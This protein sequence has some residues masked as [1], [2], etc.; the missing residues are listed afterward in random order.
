[1]EK[2]FSMEQLF[3][4]FQTICSLRVSFIEGN[5]RH[6]MVLLNL[7][8][9]GFPSDTKLFQANPTTLVS[10]GNP[11]TEYSISLLK[12]FVKYEVLVSLGVSNA[13]DV[14]ASAVTVSKAYNDML[15]RTVLKE[16]IHE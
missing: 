7:L 11:C 15:S 2:A 3:K 8:N 12:C 5:H 6:A 10:T 4:K 1:M 13:K 9:V 14:A 16:D